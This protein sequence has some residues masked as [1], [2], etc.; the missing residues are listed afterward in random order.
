MKM[1]AKDK[2]LIRVI[3]FLK[4]KTSFK[5]MISQLE[6]QRSSRME[7]LQLPLNS[8]LLIAIVEMRKNCL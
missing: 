6:F 8:N 2:V 4:R 1:I 5:V 3:I 7:V